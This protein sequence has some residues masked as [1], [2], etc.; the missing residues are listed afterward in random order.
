MLN[1]FE[2]KKKKNFDGETSS[3]YI[4]LSKKLAVNLAKQCVTSLPFLW[5]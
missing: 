5:G 2:Q 3:I 1:Q 4:T